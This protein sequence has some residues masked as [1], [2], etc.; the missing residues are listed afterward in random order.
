VAE[1]DSACEGGHLSFTADTRGPAGACFY[2]EITA[3]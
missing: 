3:P 2:Y 1:V